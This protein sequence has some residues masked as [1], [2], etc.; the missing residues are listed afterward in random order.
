MQKRKAKRQQPNA[1]E[2]K[3]LCTFVDKYIFRREW[4]MLLK[5]IS[6]YHPWKK[7]GNHNY[8]NDNQR[9]QCEKMKNQL[10]NHQ[11]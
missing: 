11:Y 3:R 6:A 10:P 9:R 2:K 1:N 8:K 5:E 7:S 4:Q